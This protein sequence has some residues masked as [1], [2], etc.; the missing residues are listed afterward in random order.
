MSRCPLK[1]LSWN[2]GVHIRSF[3]RAALSPRTQIAIVTVSFFFIITHNTVEC[4]RLRRV[5]WLRINQFFCVFH[6]GRVCRFIFHFDIDQL[7]RMTAIYCRLGFYHNFFRFEP[8]KK[9]HA[10][11]SSSDVVSQERFSLI[12]LLFGCARVVIAVKCA[13]IFSARYLHSHCIDIRLVSAASYKWVWLYYVAHGDSSSMLSTALN[14]TSLVFH[15]LI[16]TRNVFFLFRFVF[17]IIFRYFYFPS[18]RGVV[19]PLHRSRLPV[20]FLMLARNN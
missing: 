4:L 3:I 8:N 5:Y 2:F 20:P 1:A 16:D 7:H 14:L 17:A 9:S 6:F 13:I 18:S 15:P 11:S 19:R 12:G 10:I